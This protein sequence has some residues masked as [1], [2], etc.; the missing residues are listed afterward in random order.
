M[1]FS[2]NEICHV[3]SVLAAE[4]SPAELED[5]LRKKALQWNY[6]REQGLEFFKQITGLENIGEFS[7]DKVKYRKKLRR[8]VIDALVMLAVDHFKSGCPGV[9]GRE[10]PRYLCL[11]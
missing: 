10:F 7:E 2:Y 8:D 1:L 6:T 3:A 9:E 11:T 5:H 4:Q